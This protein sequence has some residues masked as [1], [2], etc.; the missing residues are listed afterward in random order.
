MRWS[1]YGQNSSLDG[2]KK[3]LASPIGKA[4]CLAD[5]DHLAS[6][7]YISSS[8]ASNSH[9]L[10]MSEYFLFLNFCITN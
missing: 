5:K 3:P 2:R 10:S 1:R 9:I 8:Q 6:D 4:P 7:S